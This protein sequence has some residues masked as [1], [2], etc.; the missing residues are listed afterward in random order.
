M[1]HK[2][3]SGGK[4]CGKQGLELDSMR[5]GIGGAP[6]RHDIVILCEEDAHQAGCTGKSVHPVIRKGRIGADMGRGL[7]VFGKCRRHAAALKYPYDYVLVSG[8]L[9]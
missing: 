4:E 2:A 5:Q 7:A 8:V 6:G 3:R 9:I 1:R